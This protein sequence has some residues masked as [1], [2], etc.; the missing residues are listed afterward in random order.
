LGDLYKKLVGIKSESY[1]QDAIEARKTKIKAMSDFDYRAESLGIKNPYDDNNVLEVIGN[2]FGIR[3]DKF[4]KTVLGTAAKTGYG[5]IPMAARAYGISDADIAK[6]VYGTNVSFNNKELI[7][8]AFQNN[9]SNNP[10]EDYGINEFNWETIQ[11]QK[12]G[13][14]MIGRFIDELMTSDKNFGYEDI[15]NILNQLLKGIT[16]VTLNSEMYSYVS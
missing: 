9:L 15:N 3:T 11:S 6:K 5:Y 8:K 14:E 13:Y 16:T 10:Q 7:L 1:K 2:T 4:S 12:T